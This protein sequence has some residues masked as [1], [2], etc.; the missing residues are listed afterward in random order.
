MKISHVSFPPNG[1]AKM[2]TRGPKSWLEINA[3]TCAQLQDIV[4]VIF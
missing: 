4:F 2:N 1:S 3:N